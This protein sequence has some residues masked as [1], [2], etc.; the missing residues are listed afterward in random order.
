MS[1]QYMHCIHNDL[2]ARSQ[3]FLRSGDY[4][5]CSG[6][7]NFVKALAIR[8][9]VA[10]VAVASLTLASPLV[11]SAQ[12]GG[13]GATGAT[14]VST[15]VLQYRQA[16]KTYDL[17][18]RAIDETFVNAINAALAA[19]TAGLNAATT[20]AQKVIVEN[21]FVEAK[22]TAI[23]RRQAALI[24]LGLPPRPPFR[25]HPVTT[26]TGPSAS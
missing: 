2:V 17:E 16:L 21:D 1:A 13:T 11:A 24:A 8:V 4:I 7:R 5:G 26:T 25:F 15:I 9:S 19:E 12:D 22:V 10:L 3:R 18:R 14:G 6:E 20:P 23:A